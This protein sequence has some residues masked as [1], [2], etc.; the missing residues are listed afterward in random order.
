MTVQEAINNIDDVLSSTVNYDESIDY[1]L[2]SD[3]ID[4]LEKSKEALEKQIP[5]KPILKETKCFDGSTADFVFICSVCNQTICIEPEDDVIADYIK[6][7]YSHCHCGQ[8]L[9]WG[10][11]E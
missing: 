1:Q 8:A 9:D 5:R 11:I 2:T 6:E 10:D 7:E 3:D 4:W